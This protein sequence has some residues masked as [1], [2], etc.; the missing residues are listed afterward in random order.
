MK[1]NQSS[2]VQNK[3]NDKKEAIDKKEAKDKK[4]KKEKSK[5]KEKEN[6]KD[7]KKAQESESEDS[8]YT[9]E[10][11]VLL[12]KFHDF[13][14]HKFD[15]NDIYEVMLKFKNDEELIKNELKEMLKVFKKGDEYTWTEIGKSN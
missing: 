6:K 4:E 10:E 5:E 13:S 9:P 7:N 8:Y 11:I 1:G 2:K 12:D 15:D 14:G 3:K